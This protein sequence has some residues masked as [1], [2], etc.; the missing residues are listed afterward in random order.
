LPESA[1]PAGRL[2]DGEVGRLS[3]CRRLSF[4][5]RELRPNQASMHEPVVARL[6]AAGF[7]GR[8][9]V[10]LV[11][12]GTGSRGNWLAPV[13]INAKGRSH[14]ALG[15]GA[16]VLG[17]PALV[18]RE[19]VV[20][21][22]CF[23]C[24]LR[25]VDHTLWSARQHLRVERGRCL[26]LFALSRNPGVLVFVF[27][28]AGGAPRLLDVGLHH[29]H[30]DVVGQPPLSRAVVVQSVTKPKLALHQELPMDLAGGE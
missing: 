14:R 6:G 12:R 19:L 7:V 21:H 28:V 30:D 22:E 3:W 16:I 26:A 4:D 25:V 15:R 10:A 5:A 24:R 27:G 1:R 18:L 20:G 13:E 23:G 8:V 17:R 2:P 29:G 11:G 9:V